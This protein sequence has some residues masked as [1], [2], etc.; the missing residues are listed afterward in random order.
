MIRDPVFGIAM[1]VGVMNAWMREWGDRSNFKLLRYEDCSRDAGALRSVLRFFGS[2]EVDDSLFQHSVAFSSFENMKAMEASGQFKTR[3]LLPADPSDA[4]S[5]KVRRG[6]VGGYK[7]YLSDDDL[8][9]VEQ[10][11]VQL[12][13]RYAYSMDRGAPVPP[14][15]FS[16]EA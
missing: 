9:Y 12:N 16:S 3:I 10:A 13:P 15:M 1:I 7:E 4:D 8:V 6:V 5:F 11:M 14:R 2:S